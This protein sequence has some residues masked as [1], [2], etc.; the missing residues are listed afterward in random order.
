MAGPSLSLRSSQL[1][2]LLLLVILGLFSFASSD[3][4]SDRAEC[5]NQLT[6]LATC[7]T[8]VENRASTPTPDCCSGLKQVLATNRKCLC[9]LIKDRDEPGLGI[10]LNVTTAMALPSVCRASSNISECPKLLNLPPGSAE[11]QIFEQYGRSPPAARYE[12]KRRCVDEQRGRECECT[13]ELPWRKEMV[14][15]G[16]GWWHVLIFSTSRCLPAPGWLS[17]PQNKIKRD[18]LGLVTKT[19]LSLC[20]SKPLNP[21]LCLSNHPSCSCCWLLPGISPFLSVLN[22]LLLYLYIYGLQCGLLDR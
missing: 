4:A 8:Y 15:S 19:F 5:A 1:P 12:G 9:V 3:F 14:G 11:A 13:R 10:K 16:E 7:L 6:G 17:W 21:I 2:Y 18:S 22:P 20:T